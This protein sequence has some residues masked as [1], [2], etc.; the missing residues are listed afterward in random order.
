MSIDF[1]TNARH[2]Q[3]VTIRTVDGEW[4]KVIV[5]TWGDA[6]IW[7]VAYDSLRWYPWTSILF[8]Q[9]DEDADGENS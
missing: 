1:G 2:D 3:T 9:L 7:A 8:V 5:R 4:A 6:G